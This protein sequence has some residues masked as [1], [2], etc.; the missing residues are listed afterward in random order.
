M[1]EQGESFLYVRASLAGKTYIGG[2]FCTNDAAMQLL[3]ES[4]DPG[5]V[6]DINYA[7]WAVAG[8][9][10]AEEVTAE[11]NVPARTL[12]KVAHCLVEIEFGRCPVFI[13]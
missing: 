5:Q 11:L 9:R 8:G 3:Y 2:R 1:S 4:I 10:S 13:D 12:K 6:Q 7:R